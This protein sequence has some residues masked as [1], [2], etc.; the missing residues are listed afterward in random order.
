M[1]GRG[2]ASLGGGPA[3]VGGSLA[4]LGAGNSF[5]LKGALL[6][7]V[8]ALFALGFKKALLALILPL[9][10]VRA[11]SSGDIAVDH[12]LNRAFDLGEVLAR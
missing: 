9:W 7:L 11:L 6:C 5:R 1:L 10:S 8:G 12:T 4:S 3:S 2:F